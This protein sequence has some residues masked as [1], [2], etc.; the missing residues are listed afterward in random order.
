MAVK[1]IDVYRALDEW[2]PFGSAESN[3]NVG[4]LV[5][6]SNA[7]VTGILLALDL[8]IEVIAQA[9]ELGYN[10]VVTHH[11]VIYGRFGEM[12]DSHATGRL[13]Y[14]AARAGLSVICAHTNVDA[15][16]GGVT[17]ALVEALGFTDVS[18]VDSNPMLRIC[19][20]PREMTI[21]ELARHFK[22][23]VNAG[24]VQICGKAP[25]QIRKVVLLGGMGGALMDEAMASGADVYMLGE[26]NHHQGLYMQVMGG[27]ALTAGHYETEVPV[28][29]KIQLYL[30]N[31][32][33]HV[34]YNDSIKV[35]DI[36]TGPFTVIC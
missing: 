34:K 14:Q 23:A 6:D 32:L 13:V 18:K 31:R 16:E 24:A 29:K 26:L 21:N 9:K 7:E 22:S 17:D 19:R 11:P 8:T 1:V 15:A 30:Q 35:T 2:A 28:L 10:L 27:C 4:L 25:E 3:D 20:L 33:F 12:S 36:H 5:G